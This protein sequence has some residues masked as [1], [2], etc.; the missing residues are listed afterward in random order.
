MANSLHFDTN[1]VATQIMQNKT[2]QGKS[3]SVQS[4]WPKKN[5]I[6]QKLQTDQINT[7]KIIDF[8]QVFSGKIFRRDGQLLFI[9]I[10]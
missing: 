8:N 4:D 3:Q 1:I 6:P 5:K 2:R 7:P 10:F 9:R